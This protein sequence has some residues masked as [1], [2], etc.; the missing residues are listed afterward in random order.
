[1][2]GDRGSYFPG[3]AY[4]SA[5]YRGRSQEYVDLI[6]TAMIRQSRS[7]N[8]LSSW[9][10]SAIAALSAR[11]TAQIFAAAEK[12]KL[13]VRA[14]MGQLTETRLGPILQYRPASLDHMDYVNH[15]DLPA[16]AQSDTVATFV[17]GANYFLGLARY[18]D[19]RRLVAS[20]VAIAL[21]TDY[22]PAHRQR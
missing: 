13:A 21:A 18:P 8:W 10:C 9:M 11:R 15:A 20:G 3:R 22:N 17:P 14:H 7:A 19:A 1:V 16:L 6:C 2:G 12:H 5:E 4:G